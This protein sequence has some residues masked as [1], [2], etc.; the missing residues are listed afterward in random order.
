[1]LHPLYTVGYTSITANIF[2]A[3]MQNFIASQGGDEGKLIDT[4]YSAWSRNSEYTS[5]TFKKNLGAG[6]VNMGAMFGNLN[7]KEPEKGITIARPESYTL[8]VAMLK[9]A[10]QIIMCGCKDH[11]SCHRSHVAQL[12]MDAY[13]DH[14]TVIHLTITDIVRWSN[15]TQ[16]ALQP[17]PAAPS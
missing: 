8:L 6:Y 5:E 1:M 9:K 12:V 11:T 2:Y 17:L 10:P 3:A 13:P 14:A 4:R 7:Y 15:R 16:P